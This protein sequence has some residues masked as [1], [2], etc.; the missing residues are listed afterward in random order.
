[1][2][3][4]FFGLNEKP[5]SISPDPRYLFMSERHTEALAHLMYGVRESGGFIQLT[6]EV[7]TGKTTLVRSLLQQLPDTADVALILNPQ[8]SKNEFLSTI[9][10]ELG[11]KLP[12]KANSIKALINALN[13]YLLENHSRAHRT[14]LIVDEAQN[15]RL[16]VLEQ[17]RL[18]TNLETTKQ[19]LLQIILIGQPEL[20]D[21]LSRN[22]MRQLAQ[23]VTGRYHLEPLSQHETQ[24][25]IEHRLKVAGAVGPIF[26]VAGKK[27]LYRLSQGVPRR[28]NVIA[29][30]ALL[31]AFTQEVRQV[32]PKLLR[33]AAAEVLDRTAASFSP[34]YRWG[35]GAAIAAGLAAMVI[36]AGWAWSEWSHLVVDERAAAGVPEV[37]TSVAAPGATT[38]TLPPI[39]RDSEPVITIEELSVDEPP[40]PITAGVSLSAPTKAQTIDL[41]QILSENQTSTTTADAFKTLFRFWGAEYTRG[42]VAGCKQAEEFGLYCL[43]QNGSL[44]QVRRLDRP[45]IFTLRDYEGMEHQVVLSGLNENRAVISVDGENYT[46]SVDEVIDY[47]FGSYLLL[48]QPANSQLTQFIPGMRDQGIVWLRESL[49]EI[50]GEPVSPMNSMLFDSEL[51]ARVRTYQREQRLNV[52]GVVGYQTQIAINTDLGSAD[53]PRLIRAN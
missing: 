51:E 4:S 17:V 21:L 53:R 34:W 1:M 7:G 9:C 50:Q 5:F 6:G 3:T 12:D 39:T 18:L 11:V 35:R 16:D 45:V 23:R 36:G 40:G 47:W 46:V 26:T 25:Y 19:K 27:E 43:M 13:T 32:T 37:A 38:E 41:A 10:E 31:G 20:R 52:D 8:L 22:D 14:I 44:A 49:A 42:P 48:W 2:Y 30:R 24:V 29:D 33:Q 28:I 15:L